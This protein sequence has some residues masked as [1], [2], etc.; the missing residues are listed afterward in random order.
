MM[1]MMM[2]R[3]RKQDWRGGA[4][5]ERRRLAEFVPMTAVRV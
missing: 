4:A 5:K 1:M 3:G 2:V